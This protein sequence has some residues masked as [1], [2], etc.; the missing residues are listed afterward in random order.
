[1]ARTTDKYS[2]EADEEEAG[3][4]ADDDA[5]EDAESESRADRRRALGRELIEWVAATA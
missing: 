1:M 5:E 2:A 3:A 4:A